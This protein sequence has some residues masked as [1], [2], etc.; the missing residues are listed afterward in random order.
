MSRDE[1]E[2]E[3]VFLHQAEQAE[4]RS[5]LYANLCRRLAAEPAVG[6]IIESPPR[7]DA[8]LRLLTALHSLVLRG[9]AA[10]DRIEV[11]LAEHET[12]LRRMV[13]EQAIQTNEVQRCWVLLPCFL[14]AVRMTGVSTVDLVELGASAGLNLQ[15]DRFAYRYAQSGWSEGSGALTLTGEERGE[16]PAE[17]LRV[18]PS[19][20]SRIGIDLAPVDATTEE[21]ARLLKSFVWADQDWRLEL[22]DRAISLLRKEPPSI[23]LGNVVDV[24]PSL[25]A[26]RRAET[27]TLVWQTAVFG[28][29]SEAER[30]GLRDAM[31]VSGRTGGRLAFVEASKPDDGSDLYWGLFVQTFPDGERRQVGLADFHGAWIDWLTT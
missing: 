17:L 9:D 6:R 19:V 12:E 31:D 29:L 28:Y 24:L 1:L 7:W 13:A 20:G 8:P 16:V 4:G 18:R 11:A 10:W 3:G 25:L 21:G 5:A 27:L 23:E 22:L 30:Q 2:W 14:D 15:W 26:R